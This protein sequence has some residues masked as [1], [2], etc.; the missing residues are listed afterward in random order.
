[1][2]TGKGGVGSE[3]FAPCFGWQAGAPARCLRVAHAEIRGLVPLMAGIDRL[4]A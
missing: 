4:M 1:M 2:P 3:G